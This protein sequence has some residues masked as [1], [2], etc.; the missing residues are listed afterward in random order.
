MNR[1]HFLVS[2]RS[3]PKISNNFPANMRVYG[4]KIVRLLFMNIEPPDDTYSIV[5]ES[6]PL[7][8]MFNHNKVL[9][10]RLFHNLWGYCIDYEY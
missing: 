5:I 9:N 6:T 4:I 7:K 3:V 10:R 1:Q 2:H 8:A